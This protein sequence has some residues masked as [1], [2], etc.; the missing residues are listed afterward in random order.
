[1][2]FYTSDDDISLASSFSDFDDA[3][4]VTEGGRSVASTTYSTLHTVDPI[5]IQ[6]VDGTKKKQKKDKEKAKAKLAA[7][8][9]QMV[10]MSKIGVVVVLIMF[11]FIFAVATY[12]VTKS[13]NDT[14]FADR[15]SVLG[16]LVGCKIVI[17][18]VGVG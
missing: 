10:V 17:V 2:P 3:T 14:N 1:M 7:K 13:Q 8:E 16:W 9:H 4:R 12:S 15:V 11:T 6:A 5:S 18:V